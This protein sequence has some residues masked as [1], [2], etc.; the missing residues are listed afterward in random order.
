[1]IGHDNLTHNAKLGLHY[2]R[3]WRTVSPYAAADIV[4]SIDRQTIVCWLPQY[5]DMGLIFCHVVPYAAGE[6]A[7]YMSP[8][9]FLAKPHLW[10][11]A[12]HTYQANYTVAPD[13]GFRLLATRLSSRKKPPDWDLTRMLWCMTAA[14]RVRVS[15]YKALS[16]VLAPCNFHATIVA[17][18]G[19]A[20]TVVGVSGCIQPQLVVAEQRP[21]I[22]CCGDENCNMQ[23]AGVFVKIVDA[24]SRRQCADGMTGEIW[25]HSPSVAR[26]YWAKPEL[27]DQV[28]RARLEPDDG[29]TYL[30]TGDEGFLNGERLFIGGRIK[31][32]VIIAGKN[33]YPEDIEIAISEACSSEVR[34]GCVAAFSVDIGDEETLVVVFEIRSAFTRQAESV[35]ST[36]TDAVVSCIGIRPR[37]VVAIVEKTIPKTTSGKIRRR[38]TRDALHAGDLRVVFDSL[39]TQ[40]AAATSSQQVKRGD[41]TKDDD[42]YP[43]H[44]EPNFVGQVLS[45]MNDFRLVDM[46]TEPTTKAVCLQESHSLEPASDEDQIEVVEVRTMGDE[47]EEQKKTAEMPLVS[48]AEDWPRT[49]QV[50]VDA[51][52]RTASANTS[53]RAIAKSVVESVF[54]GASIGDLE[55][56]LTGAVDGDLIYTTQL[57]YAE[58]QILATARDILND[59]EIDGSTSFA[60]HGLTSQDASRLCAS[61]ESSLHVEVPF[62]LLLKP[63]TTISQLA[64]QVV[65]IATGEAPVDYARRMSRFSSSIYM[66]RCTITSYSADFAQFVGIWLVVTTL[67]LPLI[68]AYYYGLYVQWTL[69]KHSSD[70]PRVYVRRSNRPWSSFRVSSSKANVVVPGLLVP[71]VIPIYLS[72]LSCL[73]IIIKWL[74][75]GRYVPGRLVVPRSMAFLQWWFV[76][77][78]MDQWERFVGNY[79]RDSILLNLFYLC[80]GC[81]VA[82]NAKLNAFLREFDLI[83]IEPDVQLS[84]HVFARMFNKGPYSFEVHFFPVCIKAGAV[85]GKDAV[86]MPGCRIGEGVKLDPQ[87]GTVAKTTFEAHTRYYGS[88]AQAVGP[89]KCDTDKRAWA[90]A[91]VLKMCALVYVLYT[92]YFSATITS[93]W[94]FHIVDWEDITFRYRE[95]LYWVLS[96]FWGSAI[97]SAVVCIVTKWM[98]LGRLKANEHYESVLHTCAVWTVEY[99]WFRLVSNLGSVIWDKNSC[100]GQILLNLFGANVALD[101][102]MMRISVLSAAQADLV[103]IDSRADVSTCTI[104]CASADKT[105]KPVRIGKGAQVGLLARLNPGCVVEDRAIVGHQTVVPEGTTVEADV[106]LFGF[107]EPA[108]FPAPHRLGLAYGKSTLTRLRARI[109]PVLT[110]A[111][112]LLLISCVALAPS[113]ELA[114]RALFGDAR[115]YESKTYLSGVTNSGSAWKPPI[116]R[117]QAFAFV[118]PVCVLMAYLSLIL[119]FRAWILLVFRDKFRASF[120]LLG[121]YCIHG[122]INNTFV[123]PLLLGTRFAGWHMRFWGVTVEDSSLTYMNTT[124]FFEPTLLTLKAGCVLDVGVKNRAHVFRYGSMEFGRKTI[125]RGAILHPYVVTWAHDEV[126]DG[127]ILGPRSQ[128]AAFDLEQQVVADPKNLPT[129]VYLQGCPARR[130]PPRLLTQKISIAHNS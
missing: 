70:G 25:V 83:Y 105:L 9:T 44:S 128:L 112:V 15:T 35:V 73:V 4:A 120:E 76:D 121:Y 57:C 31:D 96:Y 24:E 39:G 81:N 2:R 12:A 33:Y 114:V 108:R 61:L 17:A 14:E 106:V 7:V 104:E 84:G 26:G 87:T 69:S 123:G 100:L 118:L 93:A 60:A 55:A 22:V 89:V 127:A 40:S 52:L 23:A 45:W 16:D 30:R 95:L 21:D 19:L 71:V 117:E 92:I 68:P 99:L 42:N 56:S 46:C 8:L 88:P 80:M 82:L 10:F 67:A 79:V 103:T 74:V 115:Y 41:D 97:M 38:A 62:D 36:A 130:V 129:G 6:R 124:E 47:C 119:V 50:K 78:L 11:E 72:S 54:H 63:E 101:S 27:S 98:W 86:I 75:V 126:P 34:P 59:R 66:K 58:L 110:R 90:V 65:D 29:R 5:H 43:T 53:P 13:F 18:Y 94:L 116:S 20:E 37:R 64:H 49:I 3:D 122:F 111:L 102:T 48:L 1:M 109:Q 113:Y 91:E 85:I 125:G 28:F 77:R 51:I 107:P 32:L